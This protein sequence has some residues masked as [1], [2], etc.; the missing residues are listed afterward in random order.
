M[1]TTVTRETHRLSVAGAP[2]GVDRAN[3]VIRGY[4]VA[5]SGVFKDGRGQ[6]DERSLGRIVR[7]MRE[8]EP[9]GVR[10]HFGHDS[11]LETNLGKFLGRAK[12][13]RLDGDRVRADLHLD[14]SASRT[15]SGDLAGYVLDLAASDPNA[16]GSS[17]VL[18]ADEESARGGPPIWLPTAIL[19]SDVVSEGAATS[20]FL[21]VSPTPRL[22]ARA[23]KLAELKRLAAR[24]HDQAAA[25]RRDPDAWTG[26][27]VE[28]R[29]YAVAWGECYRFQGRYEQF[30]RGSFTA[31]LGARDIP[32]LRD[33]FAGERLRA[34]GVTVA[35]DDVGLFVRATLDAG[36]P[37][38]Q[39]AAAA[40]EGGGGLS[41]GIHPGR[42]DPHEFGGVLVYG[43][44]S[45]DLAEISI[46]GSQANP[47]ALAFI[48]APSEAL[49][50]AARGFDRR[51]G[52][53]RRLLAMA[54]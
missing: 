40:L 48:G 47:A 34:R 25:A 54:Y 43:P 28:F 21:E 8:Q 9:I 17:L 15:P 24:K 52:V 29:G 36:D 3:R 23:A 49:Y 53:A 33:H 51:A 39:R 37:Q 18:Q 44:D 35:Q 14:K 22:A 13:A 46:A 1:S 41:V 26:P 27:A 45:A 38:V 10:S 6:F 5:E 20:R 32:I 2:V 19:S 30:R 50:A 4:I 31:S 11:I 42:R 7:L 16:I 12:N